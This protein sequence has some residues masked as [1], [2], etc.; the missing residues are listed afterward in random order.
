M[1]MQPL[2]DD[3]LYDMNIVLVDNKEMRETNL[4]TCNRD[5][6]TDILCFP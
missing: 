6:P 3:V 5:A 2:G 1:Q 4:E